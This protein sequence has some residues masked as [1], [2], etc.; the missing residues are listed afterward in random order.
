MPG[1][2]CKPDGK[3]NWALPI[4]AR[5]LRRLSCRL[6]GGKSIYPLVQDD[7]MNSRDHQPVTHMISG[8]TS[9]LL[10]YVL[11]CPLERLT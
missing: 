5:V 10:P 3:W 6:E 1:V 11:E 7:N 8:L 9:I 4:K 2:V